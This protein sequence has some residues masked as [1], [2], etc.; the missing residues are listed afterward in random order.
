MNKYTRLYSGLNN[1][2]EITNLNSSTAY[3]LKFEMCNNVG[4]FSDNKLLTL[5]TQAP[6][7]SEWKIL[8]KFKIINSSH[9]YLGW[10]LF[11]FVA[12]N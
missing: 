7:P 12:T 4:C 6:P 3:Q 10:F 2:I 9:L 8:P 5:S 1:S 11:F